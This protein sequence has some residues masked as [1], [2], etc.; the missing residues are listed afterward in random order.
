[1]SLR[2]SSFDAVPLG[3]AWAFYGTLRRSELRIPPL[4]I[5]RPR[6]RARARARTRAQLRA[7]ERAPLVPTT[8]EFVETASVAPRTSGSEIQCGTWGLRDESS[9][10]PDS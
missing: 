5:T 1:M 8:V 4:R 3:Q 9:G 2:Q 10:T 7:H 6:A